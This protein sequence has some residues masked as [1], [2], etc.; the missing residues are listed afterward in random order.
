MEF[1]DPKKQ[2]AH[3]IR[4][5]TGYI[6]IG[7][8]LILTTVIL[9]YQAYG[10]GIKNGEVIQNGLIFVSSK[11]G[12]ADIYVNGKKRSETTNS[13]LLLPAG[14]YSFE[15]QRQGYNPWK[16]AINLEG[17]TVQRFDYPMLFPAKLTTNVTK[18]YDMQ[19]R[20]ATQSPDRRWVLIQVA[21]DYRTFEVFDTAK[22]DKAPLA[23]TVPSNVSNLTGET[24]SWKLVEW[25]NNNN[26][27]LMQHTAT[28]ANKA[29]S[30]YVLLNREKP[31]ESVNLTN[32]LGTNPARIDLRD[33]KHDQYFVYTQED[34]RLS[35][36]SLEQP[37][38]TP[39]LDQVL[40][41]KSYGND[42]VL[43][44]TDRGAESGK[45]LI[46]LHDN[47]RSY[48]LRSVAASPAYMLEL[49]KYSGNWLMVAGGSSENR[50][51]IYK[52]PVAK[53]NEKPDAPLVPIQV[54]KTENPSYVSFSDNARFI[55]TENGQQFSVYDAEYDKRYAFTT[56]APLD[57][58]Q[59]HARW[60]DGHRLTYV[61]NGKIEVLD[62][63]NTNTATLAATEVP[64]GAFFDR[65][66][67]VLYALDAQAVKDA[68]GKDITQYVL[69]STALRTPAD[70]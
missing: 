27:V 33:K 24:H 32:L 64:Y 70:Q 38:L 55:M 9:L 69:T 26:H 43:Y 1:L 41:F 57:A 46:R 19:P 8:A 35:T 63:D 58:G 14:Q 28:S 4:L 45:V 53:L 52:D 37:Q 60:M 30:E 47:D 12:S 34:Q 13:R 67:E 5:F 39:L 10:F 68:A 6:L 65:D 16:R 2:R 20:I 62:Y 3:L 66:Y 11:P 29:S 56:K 48:T 18:R 22:S 25:A 21:A 17:G 49:T 15:L 23:V 54:L 50:T 42:M 36:A 7:I 31:E 59:T 61:S 51:Y 44:A 40:G